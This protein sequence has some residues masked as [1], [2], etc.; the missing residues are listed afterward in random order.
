MLVLQFS[1]HSDKIYFSPH[2]PSFGVNQVPMT[3]NFFIPTLPIFEL[4]LCFGSKN[5]CRKFQVDILRLKRVIVLPDG[6]TDRQNGSIS[7][8]S[9]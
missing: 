4:S 8:G 9:G 7:P 5:M 1:A 2:R 6:Q 3:R